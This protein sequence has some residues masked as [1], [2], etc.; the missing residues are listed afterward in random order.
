[1]INVCPNC[2]HNLQNK[3]VNGLSF[4]KNCNKVLDSNLSN[5][6][7]AASWQ[8]RKHNITIEQL[9]WQTQLEIDLVR[10]VH[11]FVFELGYSHDDF[12]NLLKKF[13]P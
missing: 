7:L 13:D 8:I 6:L 1:M 5:E 9:Q 3:L 10:F 2:G 4:C 12:F 11:Y